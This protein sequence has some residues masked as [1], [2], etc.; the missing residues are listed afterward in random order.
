[1]A[2]AGL[3]ISSLKSFIEC[4]I[5]LDHFENPKM[6][7]CNHHFCKTCIEALLR[8]EP[9][10][11]AKVTCPMKCAVQTVIK[12]DQTV[13]DLS[14]SYEFKGM[15][16]I[17]QK[18][19]ERRIPVQGEPTKCNMVEGCGKDVSVY[20]C[21]NIMCSS[22]YK[23][24]E[25]DEVEHGMKTDVIFDK[26]ERKLKVFC[27]K[28][29]CVC[30]HL[31][32]H[33]RFLCVYCIQRDVNHKH[34]SKNP[35]DAEVEL[36][37]EALDD[38]SNRRKYLAKHREATRENIVVLREKFHKMLEEREEECMNRY[39][40]FLKA[41]KDKLKSRIE[42]MFNEH[43]DQYPD[44]ALDNHEDILRK[45][46]LVLAI[47]KER[48]LDS[49][50]SSACPH[51]LSTK[52]IS[53]S[54]HDAAEFLSTTPLGNVIAVTGTEKL[55]DKDPSPTVL[56]LDEA[57][58]EQIQS[59]SLVSGV[60]DECVGA[61]RQQSMIASILCQN[62]A[63]SGSVV[64]PRRRISLT[65]NYR[66]Y[67]EI[68]IAGRAP[69]RVDFQMFRAAVPQASD[70]F[71]LLC[72]GE[73]GFGYKGS[74]IHWVDACG[75]CCRGGDIV[76]GD[77]TG[78]R[79]VYGDKF[80]REDSNLRHDRAGLLTMVNNGHGYVGS[81]FYIT[82]KPIPRWDGVH[83]VCGEVS[84]E[85]FHVVQRIINVPATGTFGGKPVQDVVVVNSGVESWSPSLV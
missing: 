12:A 37:K 28:H 84:R 3:D 64:I 76:N 82:S 11:S 54:K 2:A 42:S 83:V 51:Y 79:S 85:T 23:I 65:E 43:L 38:D 60:L 17:L 70:N 6:L 39:V 77:G 8:F 52:H 35:V 57:E 56:E 71:L 29:S 18:T 74:V 58:S 20:C 13:Q 81:Q 16:E 80:L 50:I 67:F 47:E 40:E 53:L 69:Q 4:A 31:C 48:I 59:T 46:P 62:R 25:E 34:C 22:C 9:D 26:Q 15:L 7:S 49:M 5:C 1:M 36:L 27:V 68:S 14:V 63:S 61:V 44:V 55:L 75:G 10:G 78:G 45:P 41:E 32:I 19:M 72:R 66:A 21:T 30:T 33:G 73:L 24:H